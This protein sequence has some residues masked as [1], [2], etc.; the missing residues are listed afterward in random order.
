MDEEL[1]QI[2]ENITTE[3]IKLDSTKYIHRHELTEKESEDLD[4]AGYELA[5]VLAIIKTIKKKE[6]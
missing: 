3:L 6:N 1:E 2:C 4:E 5:E